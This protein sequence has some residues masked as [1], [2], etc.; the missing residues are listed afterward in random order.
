ML[1]FM[2]KDTAWYPQA[3]PWGQAG[4]FCLVWKDVSWHFNH[5]SLQDGPPG[6]ARPQARG[7]CVQASLQKQTL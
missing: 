3:P 2:R 6:K 1:L 5:G 7:L 4:S